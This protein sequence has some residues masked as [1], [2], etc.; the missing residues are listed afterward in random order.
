[1]NNTNFDFTGKIVLITGG[2]GAI[3]SV[4]AE[5]F[6][7]AG[8]KVYVA[9]RS[10]PQKEKSFYEYLKM[11]VKN[12]GDIKSSISHI[13]SESKKLDIVITAAGIQYRKSSMD[14]SYEE[15]DN[16]VKTNLYGSFFVAQEAAKRMKAMNVGRIIFINSLT[17]EIGLPN[18]VAYVASRGGI[19]QI[20]KALATEWAE[21][22]ITVNCIGPGRI[23]TPMTEDVFKDARVRDSFLSLI[24]QKRPGIPEDIIGATLFLASDEA[25]YITGQS[26]YIDG[27]WLASG[28]SCRG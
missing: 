10:L 11:D 27:G 22:G 25:S 6:S 16:V 2:T 5:A 7:I 8:A 13:L 26:L 1:M 18:M 24:P 28:G 21:H 3:G 17:A 19:K 9:S 20:A 15:W 23:K 14:F 12:P 4:L